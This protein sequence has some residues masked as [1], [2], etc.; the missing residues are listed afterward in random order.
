MC[1][2]GTGFG[3]G[4]SD[5]TV[6]PDG[7]VTIVSGLPDNGTGALTVVTQIVAEML[8]VSFERV[9][10]VRGTTDALP[11]DVGSA[12]DRMT[13]VAGHAA[14]AAATQVRD[15]LAPLA[16]MMLGVESVDWE[17][18]AWQGQDG[19]RVT[20]EELAT[21]MLG[22]GDPRAHVQVTLTQ[23]RSLDRDYCVQIAEVTV[24]AETGEVH[25]DRFTTVQDVG[26]IINPLGHQ[27]QIEGGLV[28]GL[29]YALTEELVVEEG[30]IVNAHLGDYKLPTIRDIPELVSINLALTGGPGPFAAKAIGELSG[31]SPAAAVAN[32]VA[33]AIGAPVF[34]LPITPERVLAALDGRAQR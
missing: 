11:T 19:R 33:D 31:V 17:G 32:A 30:R 6:N 2:R 18:G 22:P 21:E 28:Q 12:A 7:T 20:L 14:L 5:V 9:R 8:G 27:G 24:D 25:L 29:G 15:Q 26:T 13:N 1:E 10:L 34:D 16:A 3:E 23:P 4:S